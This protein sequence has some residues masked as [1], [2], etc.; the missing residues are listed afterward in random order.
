M[1]E[2]D[3]QHSC[4]YQPLPALCF[5]AN[6]IETVGA[7]KHNIKWYFKVGRA[8]FCNFKAL[9]KSSFKTFIIPVLLIFVSYSEIEGLKH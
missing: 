3:K 4:S 8:L 1:R 9:S 2:E 5:T 6:S 7:L